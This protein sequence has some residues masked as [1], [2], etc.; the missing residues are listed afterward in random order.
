[1][2]RQLLAESVALAL[3]GSAA[4]IVI[5]HYAL[6]FL[7]QQLTRLP[8]PLPHL[9]RIALDGRVLSF[10]IILCLT[11]A[12][13]ISVAPILMA[14]K[15]DLQ[16]VLRSG[17]A[18]GGSRTSGRLFS[19]LIASESAFAFLLLVGSGLMIRSLVRLEEADHGFHPDHVLTMR[20]PVGSLKKPR[21]GGKY[22]TKPEQMA[23][24]HELVE[25][26]HQVPGVKA[27]AVVNNL[28]L[29][30]VNTSL[31]Q[32]SFIMEQNIP[33]GR[34]V[35]VAGRTI[36][37]EYFSVMGTRLIAGRF[38][39]EA[40]QKESPGVAIINERLAR[41]LFPGRNAVG[42]RLPGQGSGDGAM[43][44]GVVQ[45]TPQMSYET[46][47]SVEIYL[48]Y[49]QFIF[50]AFMSTIVVRTSGDPLALAGAL[51]KAIW[52]VD[53]TQ[54]IVKV[55]TLN[56]VI[57]DAIWRPRF[58]AW[59]F[60]VLGGLALLLTSAGVYGVV[61]YTTALRRRE[62]GIRVAMGATPRDII[63]VILRGAMI[64]LA[65]GLALSLVAALLLSRLL[66]S[67]LYEISGT[68]PLAYVSA[69][70]LLLAIGSVASARPAWKA[71][72]VDPM[73]TL[74]AE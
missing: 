55:E 23:Y 39:S 27:L 67:V 15:T 70:A 17:H 10:D 56:D 24:Y 41:E 2:V 36:S 11:L 5:A 26:L 29:S 13:I 44:V 68:D 52:T 32:N 3:A 9:Q 7:I 63:G 64:P 31:E 18:S 1:M 45:N 50:G 19:V 65:T 43:V 60:S 20:V 38:F 61:A 48:P 30:N 16:A 8:I 25:K 12:C 69:A 59:V 6:E 4:G 54:P 46:P 74:R 73:H 34:D 33:N 37:P 40:D 21:P 42:E 57:A 47:P 72:T 22:D 51:K 28:P 14:S 35:L 62:V 71:A 49:T 66:T 53:A 58:S